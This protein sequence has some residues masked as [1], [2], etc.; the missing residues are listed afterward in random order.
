MDLSAP[1]AAEL[2]RCFSRCRRAHGERRRP[3]FFE[4]QF[5]TELDLAPDGVHVQFVGVVEEFLDSPSPSG[6]TSQKNSSLWQYA[7]NVELYWET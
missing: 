6:L 7:L 5:L 2:L 1:R 3:R 4:K